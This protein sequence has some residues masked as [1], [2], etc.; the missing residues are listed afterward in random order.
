[1]IEKLGRTLADLRAGVTARSAGL[2]LI[3][4]R[5]A[6]EIEYLVNIDIPSSRNLRCIR[7]RMTSARF[8]AR[9]WFDLPATS[10]E[11]VGFVVATGTVSMQRQVGTPG[12][13]STYRL[14]KLEVP[15]AIP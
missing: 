1:M 7:T 5:T 11:T 12:S 4:K 10:A 2:L 13:S 3:V 8:F 15:L 9:T 6:S 14:P